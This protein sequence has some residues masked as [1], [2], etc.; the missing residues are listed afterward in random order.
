MKSSSKFAFLLG[1]LALVV[2][3]SVLF[4]SREE[5][6]SSQSSS[7]TPTKQTSASMARPSLYTE[8]QASNT[9]SRPER[10]TALV[11]ITEESVD[12]A[13]EEQKFALLDALHEAASTYNPEGI[14]L[15]KPSLYSSDRQIRQAAADAM[16]VLGETGG[17]QIL[18]EAAALASDSREAL[19]LIEKAEYLELPSGRLLVREKNSNLTKPSTHPSPVRRSR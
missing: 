17:A 7:P 11:S 16:V 6:V 19:A 15:I 12:P 5:P 2:A 18:R 10:A 3:V 1:V 8:T 13:A 4:T 14:P 9:A